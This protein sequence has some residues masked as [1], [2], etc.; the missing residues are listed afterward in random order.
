MSDDRA[1]AE[2][3][4]ID[5]EVLELE[6][7][8]LRSFADP[9]D[10]QAQFNLGKRYAIGEDVSQN[11]VEAV[12]WYRKAAEGGYPAAQNDLG[13]MYQNGRGCPARRCGSD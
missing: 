6:P 9:S 3:Q 5:D 10:T 4:R 1:S 13:W 7:Q 8:Q 2:Y 12:K 11:D